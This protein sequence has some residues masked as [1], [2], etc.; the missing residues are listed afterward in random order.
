MHP[1]AWQKDYTWILVLVFH[2]Q[3]LL[4]VLS[5][6]LVPCFPV[7]GQGQVPACYVDREVRTACSK[8][9]KINLMFRATVLKTSG[10]VGSGFVF[11]LWIETWQL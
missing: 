6:S 5:W 7:L 1:Q 2:E 9:K 3:K 10:R 8:A 11:F 4:V